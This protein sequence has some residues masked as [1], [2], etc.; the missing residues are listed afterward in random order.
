VLIVLEALGSS[1][2]GKMTDADKVV[3]PEQTSGSESR[4]SWKSELN[5]HI[6]FG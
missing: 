1:A 5:S 2:T 6:T 4:V 3:N